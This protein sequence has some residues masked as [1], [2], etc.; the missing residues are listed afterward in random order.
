MGAVGGN[1]GSIDPDLAV[2][3][4]AW[5]TLPEPLKAG[6]VAMVKAAGGATK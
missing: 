5:A 2:L 3:I 4:D 1:L 6:I